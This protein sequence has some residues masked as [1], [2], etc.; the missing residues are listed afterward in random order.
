MGKIEIP[1][2][3]H[4]IRQ[5]TGRWCGSLDSV[6][7]AGVILQ[8]PSGMMLF[9][10]RSTKA[11]DHSGEWCLPAGSIEDGETPEQAARRECQEECGFIIGEKL[12]PIDGTD[13]FIT[14]L[15]AVPGP[16]ISV[17]STDEHVAWAWASPDDPPQ[18]LHPGVA[19]TL[20]QWKPITKVANL[21]RFLE[22]KD[23][24]GEVVEEIKVT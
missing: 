13:T 20:K 5:K 7:A 15:V 2:K 22:V 14:F 4:V 21:I 16:F 23:G 8:E 12:T 9:L 6:S 11:S 18:P 10:K 19:D 24:I 17:D 1:H 3:E